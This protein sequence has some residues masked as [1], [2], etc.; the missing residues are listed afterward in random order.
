MSSVISVR[1]LENR[2]ARR[3]NGPVRELAG[4]WRAVLAFCLVAG[5]AHAPA[6]DPARG[7]A[8]PEPLEPDDGAE[9][10][11]DTPTFRWRLAPG[12]DAA[13]IDL[14]W[15][16]DCR[17]KLSSRDVRGT[18]ATAEPKLQSGTYYWRL[19]GNL[20]DAPGM[21]TSKPR[22]L[23]VERRAELKGQFVIIALPEE[24]REGGAR[25]V[26][27]ADAATRFLASM[28]KRPLPE[29]ATPIFFHGT[30]AS[31]QRAARESN[32]GEPTHFFAFT[33]GPGIVHEPFWPSVRRP[34]DAG[35]GRLEI[36][37][38]HEMSHAYQATL[39]RHYGNEPK[40]LREGMADL[41]AAQFFV[42]RGVPIGEQQSFN[43]RL[44]AARHALDDKSFISVRKLLDLDDDWMREHQSQAGL[45][46][47]EAY[48]LLAMVSATPDGA[49]R[50]REFL[51]NDLNLTAFAME[52]R[53]NKKFCE[54]FGKPDELD[55]RLREWIVKQ[56]SPPWEATADLRTAAGGGFVLDGNGPAAMFSTV[57]LTGDVRLE[58]VVE[59]LPTGPDEV[60]LFFGQIPGKRNYQITI[61][62]HGGVVLQRYDGKAWKRIASG[63]SPSGLL[64][65]GR[66]ATFDVYLRG[67][68]LS[69]KANDG[70]VFLETKLAEAPSGRW[71]VGTINGPIFVRIAY[72]LPLPASVSP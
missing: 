17:R 8:P 28:F 5:C 15:D 11:T 25:I 40:W 23:N 34:V 16:H 12:T 20:H 32:R 58:A 67:D 27:I 29:I 60:R 36:T 19:R 61:R 70:L 31:Y 30:D 45:F 44:I 37:L 66:R 53:I 49:A 51:Q 68:L 63:M 22:E 46:Y 69:V 41:S 18:S 59:R 3:L 62:D 1:S 42:E 39:F 14:C 47:A 21:D 50:L 2:A 24:A 43:D 65:I 26:D 48:T 9:V 10:S 55:A 64:P 6:H 13:T 38:V 7:P 35:P 57:E 56:G 33:T 52:S 54:R 4:T 72:A 71:G